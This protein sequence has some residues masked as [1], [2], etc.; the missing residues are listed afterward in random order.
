MSSLYYLIAILSA[1]WVIY[2]VATEQ[3]YMS[4]ANKLLWILSA[5]FFS[6]ITAIIYYFM[7]KRR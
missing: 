3:R 6:V 4:N 5:L 7:V 2:D 1:I